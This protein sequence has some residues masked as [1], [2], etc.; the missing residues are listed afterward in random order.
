MTVNETT[1]KHLIVMS[2]DFCAKMMEMGCDSVQ[3]IATAKTGSCEWLK[4]NR[5]IGNTFARMGAVRDWLD[6]RTGETLAEEIA[7][8][9]EESE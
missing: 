1:A 9:L 5:G 2:D 8:A 6:G 3:V 4:L 7:T